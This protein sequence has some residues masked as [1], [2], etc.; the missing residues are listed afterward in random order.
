[1]SSYDGSLVKSESTESI[2]GTEDDL[3]YNP[4]SHEDREFYVVWENNEVHGLFFDNK[5]VATKKFDDLQHDVMERPKAIVLADE[6]FGELQYFGKRSDRRK[7]EFRG[8]WEKNSEQANLDFRHSRVKDLK[9]LREEKTREFERITHIWL[10]RQREL[11]AEVD[12]K[13]TKIGMMRGRIE[14]LEDRIQ[15]GVVPPGPDCLKWIDGSVFAVV[16]SIV[17]ITNL[18]TMTVEL[19]HPQYS[20]DLWGLDESFLIFYLAELT[21]KAIYFQT[22]LLC[23]PLRFVVWHWLDCVIVGVGVADQWLVPLLD[24]SSA[25]TG[26]NYMSY[27]RV[28]RLARLGRVC[29]IVHI[30]FKADMDWAEGTLFQTFIMGVIGLNAILMGIEMETQNYDFVWFYVEQLLLVIFTFEIVIRL[31][32]SGRYFFIAKNDLAWNWLDFVIVAGG[33]IDQWMVPGYNLF[34]TLLGGQTGERTNAVSQIMNLLRMARLLRILRLVR[35][36]KNIPPLYKLVYGIAQAMQGMGWVM[37]LTSAVLYIFALMGVK[38][39]GPHGIIW[40]RDEEGRTKW[41]PKSSPPE[42][43]TTAFPDIFTAIFN[44]F[45]VMNGD[46]ECM[47]PLMGYI[48]VMKF[49]VMLYVVLTNWAIFSILTAVVSDH[50]ARVTE[51]HDEEAKALSES[52]AKEQL[53]LRIF[54]ALDVDGSGAICAKEL[55]R[56]VEDEDLFHE[57]MKVDPDEPEA[58]KLTEFFEG[59][60]PQDLR[61]YVEIFVQDIGEGDDAEAVTITKEEFLSRL[62]K[63]GGNINQRSIMRIENRLQHMEKQLVHGMKRLLTSITKGMDSQEAS[64]AAYV[65]ASGPPPRQ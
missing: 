29:K 56:I 62:L 27:L 45:K 42:E 59:L 36:I 52:Y 40:G 30:F 18:V 53:V 44:L 9:R 63:E 31:K 32:R 61:D 35:L 55:K 28:F 43:V 39:F 16:A 58:A 4:E 34:L 25:A 6:A 13:T 19:I 24:T 37:I 7:F 14:D 49:V 22:R 8:W 57:L 5:E 17:I 54:H 1:M 15:N 46:M 41:N 21:I 12:D 33:I 10:K 3:L 65:A 64:A 50:M 20:Q 23:G 48:P 51:Q 60:K 38:L 11:T 2:N 26:P 47:E